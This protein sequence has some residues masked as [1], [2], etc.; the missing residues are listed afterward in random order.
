[1]PIYGGD[2][3]PGS[4]PSAA[5][6]SARSDSSGAIA[7]LRETIL[8]CSTVSPWIPCSCARI[9]FAPASCASYRLARCSCALISAGVVRGA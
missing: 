8:S 2:G 4:D 7:S 5:A 6:S 1:M 9:R 3:S